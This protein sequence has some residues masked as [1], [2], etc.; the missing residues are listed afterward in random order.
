VRVLGGQF[1]KERHARIADGI[2]GGV[3]TDPEAVEDD[4][5]GAILGMKLGGQL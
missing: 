2:E 5:N 1:P 4:Q 3:P